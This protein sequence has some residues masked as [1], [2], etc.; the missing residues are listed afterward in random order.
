MQTIILFQGLIGELN[1]LPPFF[2]S[3]MLEALIFYISIGGKMEM[4]Y[5]LILERLNVGGN[6]GGK[7]LELM[8]FNNTGKVH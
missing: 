8:R 5:T 6:V 7:I 2:D 3:N 4:N 1:E